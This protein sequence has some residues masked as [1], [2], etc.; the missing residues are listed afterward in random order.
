MSRFSTVLLALVAAS[1]VS[2]RLRPSDGSSNSVIALQ[3]KVKEQKAANPLFSEA[4]CTEMFATMKKLGG[5]VPPNE[6]VNGCTTV[7]DSVK[8]M[9]EYSATPDAASFACDT[10]TSY[11]CVYPGTPPTG[12]KELGC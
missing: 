12:M 5:S 8:A 11:G 7:C 10:G 6:V 1:A 9:K 2:T 4:T 3:E